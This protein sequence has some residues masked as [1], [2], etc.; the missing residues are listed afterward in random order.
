MPSGRRRNV[1][2]A[3]ATA[4][5]V[6][7]ML[8]DDREHPRREELEVARARQ[9]SSVPD[10]VAVEW[11]G[12]RDPDREPRVE[13]RDRSRPSGQPARSSDPAPSSAAVSSPPTEVVERG[14]AARSSRRRLPTRARPRRP[15]TRP[16]T[17]PRQRPG[18]GDRRWRRTSSA[19]RRSE[20][21]A[22]AKATQ[23]L[24]G[25]RS[26]VGSRPN[27]HVPPARRSVA[28]RQRSSRLVARRYSARRW[29]PITRRRRGTSCRPARPA[30]SRSRKNATDQAELYD[31]LTPLQGHVTDADLQ[32]FFKR[33]T[34][35]FG[36][37]GASCAPSA[38]APGSRSRAT[39]GACRTSRARPGADVTFGA[40][41]ATAE[42]RQLIME[43]LRGPG[44]V[45]A[46]DVPGVD[47][48]ALALSGR[49]FVPERGRPR[50]GCTRRST[51]L[52]RA[53]RQGPA[54]RSGHRRVR[55]RDQ[56]VL[57]K[58]GL[59][60]PALDAERRR[61]DRRAIGGVFGAGGGR[62]GPR[63]QF[64][65]RS[66]QARRRAGPRRSGR[67]CASATTPRRTS[68]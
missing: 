36:A 47:A 14:T 57:R 44:R 45:A 19:A 1:S 11:H 39:A 68:P 20:T 48:F 41:W 24:H 33:A 5:T 17:P 12:H 27:E 21:S 4:A 53:G 43:L 30:G 59:P 34:L 9:G 18:A 3:T 13:E 65:A 63:A 38:R 23:C 10:E 37:E 8:P 42:D 66:R 35:G 15:R 49:T 55:R 16:A 31:G 50:R 58:A 25:R 61:R 7:T 6:P 51:L 22:A 2:T 52:A 29:R 60:H 46:L 64:L 56:R 28:R 32:R 26:V 62:R 40:G 67:T 54:D